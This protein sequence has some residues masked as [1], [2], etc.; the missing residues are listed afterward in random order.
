MPPVMGTNSRCFSRP[1]RRSRRS[2]STS[3]SARVWPIRTA[4]NFMKSTPHLSQVPPWRCSFWQEGHL[5][6]SV[7][8]HLVQKVATSRTSV[9]H[10]GHCMGIV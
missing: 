3:S 6:R 10:F 5:K 7:L 2:C 9:L 4:A 8:W 1:E